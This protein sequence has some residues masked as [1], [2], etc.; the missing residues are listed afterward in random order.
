MYENKYMKKIKTMHNSH[1]FNNYKMYF[2]KK[3]DEKSIKI[4]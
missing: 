3:N 2:F 1:H 4:Y